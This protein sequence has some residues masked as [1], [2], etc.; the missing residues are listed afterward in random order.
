MI[1]QIRTSRGGI[2]FELGPRPKSWLVLGNAKAFARFGLN[3]YKLN[4]HTVLIL[5][6]IEKVSC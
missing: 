2:S 1:G 6:T 4:K 3:F 5:K